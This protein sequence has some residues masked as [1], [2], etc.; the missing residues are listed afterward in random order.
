MP[1]INKVGGFQTKPSGPKQIN[2]RDL[3]KQIE[4]LANKMESNFTDLMV[5]EMRKSIQKESQNGAES[6]YEGMLDKEYSEK[7]AAEIDLGVRD[8]LKRQMGLSTNKE[9]KKGVRYE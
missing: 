6:F 9:L 4:D 7:L 8:Q 1:E 2:N 3:E 5:K